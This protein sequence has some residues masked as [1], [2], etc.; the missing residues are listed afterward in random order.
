MTPETEI[1]TGLSQTSH[2]CLHNNY[3]HC[4]LAINGMVP[5]IRKVYGQQLE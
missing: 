5:S 4:G 2:A 3:A 1:V